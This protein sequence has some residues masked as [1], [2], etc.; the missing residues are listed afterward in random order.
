[1]PHWVQPGA[2][3]HIRIRLDREK[4]EKPL[5]DLALARRILDSAKFYETKQRW[6]IRL[7]LLMPDHLHAIL[8]FARDKS[9][10]EVIRDWKRFHTRTKQVM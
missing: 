2:L 1:V 8:S 4:E 3:F 6:H 7:F 9:M 10:R 5:I